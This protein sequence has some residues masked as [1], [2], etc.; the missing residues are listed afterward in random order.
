MKPSR[1]N[2]ER[3]GIFKASVRER[4]HDSGFTLT[5]L[6]VVMLLAGVLMTIAGMQMSS[7]AG[8]ARVEEQTKRLYA[9]LLSAR[10][11]AMERNRVHFV[12]LAANSYEIWEDTNPGPDGDGALTIAAPADTR[13]SQVSTRDTLTINLSLGVTTFNFDHRGLISNVGTVRITN[14]YDAVYDCVVLST[15]RIRMGRYDVLASTCRS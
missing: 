11:M 13:L 1:V 7:W 4:R 3:P 14:T 15:T 8:K 6:I 10:K 9:D 12:R 2:S 5:E